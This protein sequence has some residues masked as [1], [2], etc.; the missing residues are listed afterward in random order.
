MKINL[1]QRITEGIKTLTSRKKNIYT[2]ILIKTTVHVYLYIIQI[3]FLDL[4]L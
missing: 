4:I 2:V 3:N 1:V